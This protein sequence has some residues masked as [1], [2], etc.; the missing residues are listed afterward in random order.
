MAVT[1][2]AVN[3]SLGDVR[4]S[5][6]GAP[7]CA[8]LVA[9]SSLVAQGTFAKAEASAVEHLGKRAAQKKREGSSLLDSEATSIRR[10]LLQLVSSPGRLAA[11]SPTRSVVVKQACKSDGELSTLLSA[12]DL[13]PLLLPGTEQKE[14]LSFT[15]EWLQVTSSTNQAAFV[16]HLHA[17]IAAMK[18]SSKAEEVAHKGKRKG[19]PKDP[20]KQKSSMETEVASSAIAFLSSATTKKGCQLV[21]LA[22]FGELV[23]ACIAHS[24]PSARKLVVKLAECWLSQGF[25]AGIAAKILCALACG[26]SGSGVGGGDSDAGVCC[27]ALEALGSAAVLEGLGPTESVAAFELVAHCHASRYGAPSVVF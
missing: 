2:A 23:N 18:D 10:F 27:A 12:K 17:Q 24:L 11:A 19:G 4:A 16:G 22:H 9:F 13:V 1:L 20:A 7:F 26:K 25:S 6:S 14:R 15:L 21:L 3:S 8:S 5:T